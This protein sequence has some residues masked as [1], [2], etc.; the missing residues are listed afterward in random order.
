MALEANPLFLNIKEEISSDNEDEGT[1]NLCLDQNLQISTNS[2]IRSNV[3]VQV[4]SYKDIPDIKAEPDSEDEDFNYYE[5]ISDATN[6]SLNLRSYESLDQIVKIKEENEFEFRIVELNSLS[7][8]FEDNSQLDSIVEFE[9]EQKTTFRIDSLQ[10]FKNCANQEPCVTERH[11]NDHPNQF[12]M[13]LGSNQVTKIN[14]NPKLCQ[15]ILHKAASRITLKNQDSS[16]FSIKREINDD[17][18]QAIDTTIHTSSDK[19]SCTNIASLKLED[20]SKVFTENFLQKQIL[21]ETLKVFRKK[22]KFSEVCYRKFANLSKI[23]QR[24]S[25][26]EKFLSRILLKNPLNS[27]PKDIPNKVQLISKSI[28]LDKDDIAELPIKVMENFMLKKHSVNFEIREG[29]VINMFN[30]PYY[31]CTSCSTVFATQNIFFMHYKILHATVEKPFECWKCVTSYCSWKALL[32]HLKCHDQNRQFLCNYCFFPFKLRDTLEKHIKNVHV[33]KVE[34]ISCEI[35]GRRFDNERA[36]LI[37][38]NRHAQVTRIGENKSS[39]TVQSKFLNYFVP[40][41][42]K[43]ILQFPPNRKQQHQMH[44][45][46]STV[47]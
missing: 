17:G 18:H 7:E 37:H 15:Q 33:E 3:K 8:D 30:I 22:M 10:N 13:D 45:L 14:K 31:I 23:L 44:I 2:S 19:L 32:I 5:D 27:P 28:R 25:L 46:S 29:Q 36:M 35:C 11:Q 12:L 26:N 43:I 6:G 4:L 24:P 1:Q 21:Q 16:N 38:K 40:D 42:L 20:H 41:F 9:D 39:H 47:L 34:K